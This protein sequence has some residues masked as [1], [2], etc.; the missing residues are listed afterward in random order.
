MKS[1]RP[2]FAGPAPS[3]RSLAL[4]VLLDCREGDAFI[5]EVLDRRFF[6]PSTGYSLACEDHGNL[7]TRPREIFDGATPSSNSVAALNL[8]RLSPEH[9]AAVLELGM[10]AK[11]ELRMLSGIAEPDV[12][13]ITLI[14]PVHLSTGYALSR[15]TKA[16][17]ELL[18]QNQKLRLEL[19]TRRA[20]SVVERR[21]REE[22][23]MAPPDPAAIRSLRAWPA[24]AR[25]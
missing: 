10:S 2:P 18:D 6:A 3:A 11:G 21:A 7:I 14:A 25:P 22:L 8:L 4:D 20:P 9:T 24:G 23:G 16:R 17:R 12:A 5:Q 1:S 13:V 19:D 15:E